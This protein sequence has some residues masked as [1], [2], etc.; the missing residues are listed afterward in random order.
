MYCNK[1]NRIY[2]VT[3]KRHV[4]FDATMK[5]VMEK[6]YTFVRRFPL[7]HFVFVEHLIYARLPPPLSHSVALHFGWNS[8]YQE[9]KCDV[10][11]CSTT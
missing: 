9:I 5:N 3:L 6:A 11:A 8:I 4:Q 10:S 7:T 1:T 2:G